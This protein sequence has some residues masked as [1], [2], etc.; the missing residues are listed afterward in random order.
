MEGNGN[1]VHQGSSPLRVLFLGTPPFAAVCLQHL[2]DTGFDVVGV[3]TAPDRPA[4]R[5]M[6]PHAS[7]VKEL[8]LQHGLPVL[9]P[10]KLRD[11]QFVD[12]IRTWQADVGVA[13]A[14][15]MLPEVVWSMPR[16][17]TIN[18]HASLLP[19]L[20]GA[21]PIQRAIM[22]GLTE[23]GVTTFSLNAAI[24]CGDILGSKS[25]SI[26]PDE[27]A[28]SLHDRLLE[29]GKELLVHTLRT[30]ESGDAVAIPQPA[31]GPDA[32][33]LLEAPK[34][35]KS[36]SELDWNQTVDW[37]HNRVRAFAPSPGAWF[38]HREG[39][40]KVFSGAPQPDAPFPLLVP[41]PAP[42]SLR[43]ENGELRVRCANGWY[44]LDQIQPAGKKRMLPSQWVH[45]LRGI[46]P[47]SL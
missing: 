30:M 39:P 38:A 19:Q 44:R 18:L 2:L 36:D 14:F 23:T 27:N 3:V 33:P 28:G 37:I 4:G 6:Q 13:V 8:A 26:G 11:A 41:P 16:L 32:P 22:A 25:V 35:Q 7:A 31:A 43:Y 9:Q 21:A 15:R 24:D 17:G 45:G 20:R 29:A 47:D 12:Q 34:L 1:S 10:E 42:G 40:W 46:L 5:G